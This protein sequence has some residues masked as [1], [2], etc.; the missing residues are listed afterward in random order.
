[1]ISQ[2][3]SMSGAFLLTTFFSQI[4]FSVTPTVEAV[5]DAE[6]VGKVQICILLRN[7]HFGLPWHFLVRW[8]TI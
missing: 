2:L 1:M 6:R 5:E 4:G 8:S 3:H 7:S